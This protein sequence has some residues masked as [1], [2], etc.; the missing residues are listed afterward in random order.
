MHTSRDKSNYWC[1]R[2]GISWA[3]DLLLDF[4]SGTCLA[5]YILVAPL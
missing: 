5:S 4:S 2:T 3:L 1:T